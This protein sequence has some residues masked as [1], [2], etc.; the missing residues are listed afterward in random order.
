[1]TN[2]GCFDYTSSPYSSCT[3][4]KKS[5]ICVYDQIVSSI[6]REYRVCMGRGLGGKAIGKSTYQLVTLL[7]RL[8]SSFSLHLLPNAQQLV[9]KVLYCRF[10]LIRVVMR[11]VQRT[12]DKTPNT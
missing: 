10:C 9:M 1:M 8:S 12:L 7:G 11:R 6:Q 3:A 5:I 4:A 2:T